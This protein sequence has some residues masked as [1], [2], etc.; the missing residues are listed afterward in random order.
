MTWRGTVDGVEGWV[1]R[2][3]DVGGIAVGDP[4][5]PDR[6]L[7]AST[8]SSTGREP[9]LLGVDDEGIA[10]FT[11]RINFQ[12][13]FVQSGAFGASSYS[14]SY[15][16]E[17]IWIDTHDGQITQRQSFVSAGNASIKVA[18]TQGNPQV[19]IGS[20]SGAFNGYRAYSY[21]DDGYVLF[22]FVGETSG[23]ARRNTDYAG[24]SSGVSSVQTDY[25]AADGS[26]SDVLLTSANYVST[27]TNGSF[28]TVGEF[29][30]SID[31]AAD[32]TVATIRD[33]TNLFIDGQ[34][35]A[36]ISNAAFTDVA[37]IDPTRY[38]ATMTLA[39]QNGQ[40]VRALVFNGGSRFTTDFVAPTDHIY[41]SASVTALGETRY[42]VTFIDQAPIATQLRAQVFD[43]AGKPVSSLLSFATDT[44]FA[45]NDDGTVV[46]YRQVTDAS[47]LVSLEA[48][49]AVAD[50]V[51]ITPAAGAFS[52]SDSDGDLDY[53]GTIALGYSS[54]EQVILRLESG[55]Y[56]IVGN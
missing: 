3:I 44:L 32:G 40:N 11:T 26:G 51:L 21:D 24:S 39:G 50:E 43:T 38:A 19:T 22:N 5:A 29:V 41:S 17:L 16:D 23:S 4:P 18:L 53:S 37:A 28:T 35:K 2:Q 7:I 15:S 31:V 56:E 34:L 9:R 20:S 6:L 52:V 45:P 14:R 47:G 46:A 27:S 54:G 48:Q 30:T 36:S 1:S 55:S 10:A 25:R 8:E 12:E 42:L 33:G 13:T 49:V